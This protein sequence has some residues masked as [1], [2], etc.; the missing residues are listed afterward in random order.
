MYD[1]WDERERKFAEKPVRTTMSATF[2]IW[3]I[4]V[5]VVVLGGA[6]SAGIWFLKVGTSDIRGQGD[7]V[8]I[9]NEAGN[10]IRA[11][12]G[13]EKYFQAIVASDA[14][15]NIT[16]EALKDD[17]ESLKIKTEL[18]GQKQ[19]CVD[20]VGQYNAK[21]R[22]FSQAD[23]RAADLPFEIETTN[24]QTDCKENSK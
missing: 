22:S 10:R 14:T 24:P 3:L 2:R 19:A 7:A 18:R 4:V 20:L 9:K 17:P 8:V 15:I 11:Q 1:E 21:A 13:F 5:L 6:L 12:E 23:F 16:A